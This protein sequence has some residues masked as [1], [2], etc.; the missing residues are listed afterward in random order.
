[1]VV[2]ETKLTVEIGKGLVGMYTLSLEGEG[3][4][5]V[6]FIVFGFYRVGMSY[7]E[8]LFLDQK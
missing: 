8:L 7:P 4:D 6:V 1:M 3:M 2:L 5:S